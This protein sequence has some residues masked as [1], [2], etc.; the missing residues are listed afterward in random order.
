MK[1]APL[2][3]YAF[4][5]MIRD[6]FFI[7][8]RFFSVCSSYL[9]LDP[10]KPVAFLHILHMAGVSGPDPGGAKCNGKIDVYKRQLLQ[11]IIFF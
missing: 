2:L 7:V 8:N 10:K 9:L 6:V 11:L 5:T 3:Y 1:S 4:N